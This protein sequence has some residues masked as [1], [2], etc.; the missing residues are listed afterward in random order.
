MALIKCEECGEEISDKAQ[1][2]PGCGC[3]IN[4]PKTE[5]SKC[6]SCGSLDFKKISLKNKIGA[7][8][9]FG[10]FSIGHIAKTFKCNKCGYK[11]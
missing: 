8:A 9:V 7:G 1:E 11:W 2:C 4:S 5:K 6:P 10:V 3:P